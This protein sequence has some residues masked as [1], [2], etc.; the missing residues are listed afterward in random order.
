M[1]LDMYAYKT[2]RTTDATPVDYKIPKKG[3]AEL[4]YWRKHADL[5]GWMQALYFEKGGA[6]PQFN[7]AS[8]ELDE[9]D[10]DRLERDIQAVHSPETL[11]FFFGETDESEKEDDLDFITNARAALNEGFLVYYSAWW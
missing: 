2:P 1:G 11:G 5:H 10:L 4:H 3:S 7:L 6:D 8:V 9:T